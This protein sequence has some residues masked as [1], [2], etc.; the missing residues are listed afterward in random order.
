MMP[1]PPAAE[2]PF[3]DHL[4]ELRWR[5][6]KSLGALA[7]TVALSFA[8]LTQIDLIGILARPILPLLH[9]H[10]LIFTH[11]T[12]SFSIYM[13]MSF[14]LGVILALPIIVYQAWAFLSPALHRHEKQLVAPV[15][16][17]A[18]LLFVGGVSVAYF[19]VMPL[20]LQWLL[21]FQTA[22]M[23]PMISGLEYFD[24]LFSMSLAFGLCFELPIVILVLTAVGLVTPAFL[25]KYRRHAVGAVHVHRRVP[26]ARRSDLDDDR[27]G[28]AALSA[29]RAQYFPL[30]IHV[31]APPAVAGGRRRCR[32]TGTGRQREDHGGGAA[33]RCRPPP[34]W[35]GRV[36]A[37]R[38]RSRWRRRS[39]WARRSAPRRRSSFRA[40]SATPRSRNLGRRGRAAD[41]AGPHGSHRASARHWTRCAARSPRRIRRHGTRRAKTGQLGRAG[42]GHAGV[43]AA[44][45]LWR[46]QVPGWSRRL[47]V[48]PASD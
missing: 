34:A 14:T 27:D 22:S 6:I 8:A 3:L 23:E 25:R 44:R 38:S 11:P 41:D 30:G 20:A 1:T 4:E 12:D 21:A 19:G 47:P 17:G 26:D 46:H 29:V 10:K 16:I 48:G 42:F 24:F 5:L 2:M 45:G 7:F 9:G 13:T 15:T 39:C 36:A 31:P 18:G 28:G 33:A 32:T 35:F 43:A 37:W 40:R